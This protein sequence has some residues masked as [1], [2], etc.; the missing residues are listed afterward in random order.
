MVEAVRSLFTAAQLARI[1]NVPPTDIRRWVRGGLLQPTKV[2]RRLAFF[3]FKD[4]ATARAV[5]V[6][7]RAGVTPRRI[8]SSLKQLGEWLPDAHSMLT[9]LEAFEAGSNVRVR[10]RSGQAADPSGQL[11]MDF[12]EDADRAAAEERIVELH[13]EPQAGPMPDPDS[14]EAW[15]DAGVQAEEAGAHE[16][17]VDAYEQ[18]I[19]HGAG[20][21]E[22]YFNLGN[23]LYAVGRSADAASRYLSAVDLEPD[24]VEAWNNL[25]NALT[26]SGRSGEAIRAYRQALAV[27]PHYADAHSNLAEAHAQLGQMEQARRHWRAYLRED[28]HSSWAEQVRRRL[29]ELQK[30]SQPSEPPEPDIPY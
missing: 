23:A 26:D 11:L 17:A 6:L 13:P 12:T 28:P 30:P 3:D 22:V 14:A 10:L 1:L 8:K 15:F 4:V 7:T 2:E 19:A 29:L 5:H 21:A 24:Y 27:E 16:Q 20:S 18:A 25:G 9:Q